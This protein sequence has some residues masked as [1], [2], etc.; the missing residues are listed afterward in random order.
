MLEFEFCLEWKIYKANRNKIPFCQFV[1][2]NEKVAILSYSGKSLFVGNKAK[3]Q[4]LKR[5]F[6]KNKAWEIF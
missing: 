5:V 3:R 6:Q 2:K 1:M 4:I